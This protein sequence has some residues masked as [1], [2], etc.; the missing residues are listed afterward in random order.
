[1]RLGLVLLNELTFLHLAPGEQR[2]VRTPRFA[3]LAGLW[4]AWRWPAPDEPSPEADEQAGEQAQRNQGP[5]LDDT[6]SGRADAER[7]RLWVRISFDFSLSPIKRSDS[8][9]EF[10]ESW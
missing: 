9:L 1:M 2:L 4:R 3:P 8:L 6:Q 5:G 10:E 7:G